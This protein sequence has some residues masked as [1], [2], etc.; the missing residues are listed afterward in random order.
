M[1]PSRGIGWNTVDDGEVI[2]SGEV[3]LRRPRPGGHTRVDVTMNYSD[4]PAGAVGEV[5]ANILSNPERSP[6]DDLENFAENVERGELGRPGAQIDPSRQPLRS[7]WGSME[8]S[9]AGK[10]GVHCPNAEG[11]ALGSRHNKSARSG[12][13][14][15]HR[16]SHTRPCP[17]RSHEAQ[18]ESPRGRWGRNLRGRSYRGRS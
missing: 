13:H 16:Y 10:S 18:P 8:T 9:R 7:L 15:G 4:P 6:K 12:G 14:R 17:G 2:T 11:K 1:K 3:R 5:V